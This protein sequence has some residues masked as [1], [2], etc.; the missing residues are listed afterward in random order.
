MWS[1]MGIQILGRN[2]NSELYGR[3]YGPDRPDDRVSRKISKVA[4]SAASLAIA[5]LVGFLCQALVG[6]L[7]PTQHERL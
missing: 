4:S 2:E 5:C 3:T 6:L 7:L 1:L